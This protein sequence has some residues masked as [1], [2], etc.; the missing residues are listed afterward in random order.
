MLA[1]AVV[2]TKG[3]SQAARAAQAVV[4]LADMHQ[5]QR[6]LERRIQVAAVVAVAILLTQ[7]ALPAAP[8]L[9]S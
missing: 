2:A 3:K 5:E 8:A 1:A 9:S 4:A 6:L 7:M